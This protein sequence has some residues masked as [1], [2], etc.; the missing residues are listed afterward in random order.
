MYRRLLGAIKFNDGFLAN[1]LPNLSVE[2]I[3]NRFVSILKSFPG[4]TS[5]RDKAAW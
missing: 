1:C 3:E 4:D 5:R 2:K